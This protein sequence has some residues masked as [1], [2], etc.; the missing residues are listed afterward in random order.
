[1]K[2][3][4]AKE[5]KS[6]VPNVIDVVA[7]SNYSTISEEYNQAFRAWR[8]D[9]T[10]EFAFQCRKRKNEAVY[11]EGKGYHIS[12]PAAEERRAMLR[13]NLVL[14]MGILCFLLVE[15]LLPAV[16]MV[17]GQAI[18]FD[19]SYGYSD[20]TVYGNET[21]VLIILML[22][23][24]LSYL[25]P[26]LVF[27]FTFHMPRR[28][29]Y[30]FKLDAPRELPASLAVMLVVFAVTNAWLLFSPVNF[31]S[32]TTLGEAY[33]TV[34]YMRPSYQI[35]YMIYELFVVCVLKELMLHGEILHVLRQFDDWHAVILT[36]LLAVCAS[37]SYTTILMELTFTIISGIAILRSG[38]LLPSICNRILYHLLLFS[39][40]TPEIWP[41]RTLRTY[42]PLFLS[43]ILLAGIVLCIC[44]IRPSKKNPGLLSQKHYL[45]FRE[46]VQTLLHLGPLMVI[47]CLCIAL[48]V[49]EVVF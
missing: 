13:I 27:R 39:M 5:Q 40:F 34:S 35:I 23:T 18:G 7:E 22:K 38:S 33:Y 44:S 21:V 1:M 24:L 14:G 30:H 3:T 41:N 2:K 36:A 10:N 42:R 4:T 45:S 31:L 11:V 28:V 43:C 49:I 32:S 29:A 46:R 12:D 6:N 19:I 16:L 26:I 17:V 47:F 25:A 20:N 48:M 9:E 8:N 15:N 37:H